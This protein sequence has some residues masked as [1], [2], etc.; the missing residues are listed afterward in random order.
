VTSVEGNIRSLQESDAS[1]KDE[2]IA[3]LK[4]RLRELV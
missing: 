1:G 2:A 4:R 3:E